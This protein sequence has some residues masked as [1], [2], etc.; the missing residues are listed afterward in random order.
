MS[1][2]HPE[3]IQSQIITLLGKYYSGHRNAAEEEG[4]LPEEECLEETCGQTNSGFRYR[5]GKMEAVAE[6]RAVC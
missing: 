2:F 1:V 5:W 6:E 3:K 4:G